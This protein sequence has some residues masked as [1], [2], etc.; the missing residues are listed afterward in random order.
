VDEGT[1]LESLLAIVG[2]MLGGERQDSVARG[3]DLGLGAS[4][5]NIPPKLLL[6]GR[7]IG[8]LDGITRQLDP[9]LDALEIVGRHLRAP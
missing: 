3:F 1:D 7:A 5:G 6:I 9:D 8:L 4:I 2:V